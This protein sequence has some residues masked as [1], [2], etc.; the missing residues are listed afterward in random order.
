[1]EHLL[2][3]ANPNRNA[4]VVAFFYASIYGHEGGRAVML[5][6]VELNAA[7]NPRT[8]QAH[9]SRL[10]N[11]VVIDEMT[12]LNLVVCHLHATAKFGQN[13]H[14]NVFVFEPDSQIV[15]VGL[16]VAYRLDDGVGINHSAR[17]LIDSFFQEHRVLLWL[18]NLVCR[19]RYNISPDFYHDS[20]LIICLS[21]CFQVLPDSDP[22]SRDI[23][24]EGR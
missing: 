8:S 7:A 9:E 21:V 22:L 13:H 1:M 5:R 20:I 23:S 4:A 18:P 15:L 16:L 24:S 3:L 6:P 17:T 12:L 14:L 19:N 10:Y 11:V 2:H